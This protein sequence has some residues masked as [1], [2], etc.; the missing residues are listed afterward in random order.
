MRIYVAEVRVSVDRRREDQ[1]TV[2]QKGR[3]MPP[4]TKTVRDVSSGGRTG[5]GAAEEFPAPSP[6]AFDLQTAAVAGHDQAKKKKPPRAA[7]VIDRVEHHPFARLCV[8]I[9]GDFI[10]TTPQ[11]EQHGDG[12]G[13][14]ETAAQ[15]GRNR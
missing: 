8:R 12:R 1:Q 4:G 2:G 6:G 5:Q 3:G 13:L 14:R 9:A 11:R 10:I 15:D 7:T